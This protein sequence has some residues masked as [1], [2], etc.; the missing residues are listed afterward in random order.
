MRLTAAEKHEIIRLVE[1]SDLSVRRTLRELGVHRSTFYAWYRRYQAVGAAGLVPRPAAARRHWNRIPWRV[2]HRVVEAALA[3]PVKSPREL[4]WQFTD[5]ERHF[6]SESSV[7]RI[8]KAEDL[9]TSPAYVVLSAAKTFAHPTHRPNELWQTDFTYRQVVGW[10]WYYLSTVLDDY[11]R[12]ILAWTLRTSMQASDVTETLD[13][14]RA[15]AGVDRVRVVHRPRLLSDNGP[16]YISQEL[17]D[18]LDTHGLAHTRGAPYHPMTQGKIERYHRS[19]K[20]VVKLEKYFSPWELQRALA[21]FVEDYNHRR[22]HESLQNV[23][24]ADVYHG[25]RPQILARREQIKQRTL[26]ARRRENQRTPHL[27]GIDGFDTLLQRRESWAVVSHGAIGKFVARPRRH[28]LK[29]PRTSDD[30]P[31]DGGEHGGLGNESTDHPLDEP[32]LKGRQRCVQLGACH[33]RVAGLRGDRH[34][35][36]GQRRGGTGGGQRLHSRVRIERH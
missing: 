17:A 5:R 21:R 1:G 10:G 11:S 3:D 12:Y 22:Y 13:V 19:M 33:A 26:R 2:R 24:P 32:N 4:A 27:R 34:H 36:F 35:C 7:Y 20:N 25:R 16:C 15:Q 9:I 28:A 29:V 23:T 30:E 6:L 8:L 14:A 31:E 18:Y